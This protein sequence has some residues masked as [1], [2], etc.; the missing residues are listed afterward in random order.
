MKLRVIS[1]F[2][3]GEVESRFPPVGQGIPDMW[4]VEVWYGIVV[5][6]EES[7][8]LWSRPAGKK[9]SVQRNGN[10][11][12]RKVG[13]RQERKARDVVV[14]NFGCL[15]SLPGRTVIPPKQPDSGNPPLIS[16]A[17]DQHRKVGRKKERKEED[18]EVENFG[19]FRKLLLQCLKCG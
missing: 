2:R 16:K 10:G 19:F 4:D 1:S 9:L 6:G 13:S 11:R 15:R 17:F 3:F 14:K 12:H 18:V 5:R 8:F 7:G